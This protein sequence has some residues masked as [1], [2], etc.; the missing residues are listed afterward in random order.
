MDKPNLINDIS[1]KAFDKYKLVNVPEIKDGFKLIKGDINNFL[2]TFIYP[3]STLIWILIGLIVFLFIDNI[4][5]DT[6][7]KKKQKKVEQF[8]DISGSMDAILGSD[9]DEL[10]YN[11][12]VTMNPS[13]PLEMQQRPL[14]QFAQNI[15]LN[16]GNGLVGMNEQNFPSYPNQT[17]HSVQQ[18][19]NSLHTNNGL[20][21]QTGL[22]NN[23]AN[24][25][26]TD[27]INPFGWANDVNSNTKDFTQFNVDQNQN[28]LQRYTNYENSMKEEIAK[29]LK[30]GPEFLDNMAEPDLLPPYSE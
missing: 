19:P 22:R 28:I 15:P 3:Y 21:Y 6:K 11:P 12:Q 17:F 27:I 20:D 2:Y 1:N 23:Y 7:H 29:Q 16:L 14:V 26:D 30:L 10:Q 25:Q 4:I 24:A 13:Q 8:K 18:N 5:R 9:L